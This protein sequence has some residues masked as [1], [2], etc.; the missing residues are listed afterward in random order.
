LKSSWVTILQGVEFSIFPLIVAWAL[1]QCSATALPVIPY[2]RN[3]T[4]RKHFS[5]DK[6]TSRKKSVTQELAASSGVPPTFRK[7]L[8]PCCMGV[9]SL[10]TASTLSAGQQ[11]QS[12][13]LAGT[14]TALSARRLSPDPNRPTKL[15]FFLNWH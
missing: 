13:L 10:N 3:A 5:S 14:T 6:K 9:G 2:I 15:A 8:E 4:H 12:T 1:Q 11:S 7:Q